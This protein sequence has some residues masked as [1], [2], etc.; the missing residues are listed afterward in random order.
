MQKYAISRVTIQPGAGRRVQRV[1]KR[2]P[3]NCVS[4]QHKVSEFYGALED[5]R[6]LQKVQNA[7][8]YSDSGVV[9]DV[10]AG[11]V[12]RSAAGDVGPAA[13]H[14]KVC[15]QSRNVPAGRWKKAPEGS[16]ASTNVLRVKTAKSV[17]VQR[18]DGYGSKKRAQV[19]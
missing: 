12:G 3:T 2:A 10:A 9:K 7:S 17:R 8:T 18:G 19:G 11:E 13:L 5:G 1:Q 15:N 16:N 6:R 4:K 14:A